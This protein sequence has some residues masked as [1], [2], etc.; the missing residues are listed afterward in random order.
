MNVLEYL[1]MLRE[2]DIKVWG[3]GDR[4]RCSAPAGVLTPALREELRQHKN[5]ILSFLHSAGSLARQPRAIVPLQSEGANPPI[6][7]VT[8]HNGD[9]FCYRSLARH[10]GGDQPFFGLQPPGLNGVE[11]PLANVA[12]LAAYFAAQ[13]LAARPS[14][15]CV[16]AGYCAGGTIAFELARQLVKQGAEI[17]MLALFGCPYPTSYRFLPRLRLSVEQTFERIARHG[18]A[19][20]SLPRNEL[21]SYIAERRRNRKAERAA[22]R[23]GAP[24]PAMVW[25][26]RVGRANLSAIR[27]YTP[28]TFSGRLNLFWPNREWRCF[29]D[30]LG[31]W[32]GRAYNSG[33][34]FGPAGCDGSNM[35]REPNAAAFAELFRRSVREL[36]SE[37]LTVTHPVRMISPGWTTG[38]AEALSF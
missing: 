5:E 28:R 36:Q 13:I 35:L 17:Q 2:R 11:K 23:R 32:R 8:G 38:K 14:G 3:D 29:R 19:L 10:L 22:E 24:D 21:W 7:A 12:D 15:P 33:I 30:A 26:D 34:Y 27:H 18:R 6:F 37:N 16:I 25:R 4:L 20:T 1:M 9:V 31:K